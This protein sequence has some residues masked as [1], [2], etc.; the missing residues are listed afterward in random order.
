MRTRTRTGLA[1]VAVI[2]AGIAAP[3]TTGAQEDEPEGAL[4]EDTAASTEAT[5]SV[6]E[7]TEATTTTL[8]TTSTAA[9]PV[10]EDTA[11]AETVP[12][13]EEVF[14]EQVVDDEVVEDTIPVE[15]DVERVTPTTRLDFSQVEE[16]EEGRAPTSSLVTAVEPDEASGTGDSAAVVRLVMAL[17]VVVALLVATLTARYWWYTNPKRGLAPSR[18][19]LPEG[20]EWPG[21]APGEDGEALLDVPYHAEDVLDEGFVVHGELVGAGAPDAGGNGATA[22]AAAVLEQAP[23]TRRGELVDFGAD[24]EAAAEA[25]AVEPGPVVVPNGH[26]EAG[27]W[28]EAPDGGARQVP[29]RSA[30]PNGAAAEGEARGRRPDEA[31]TVQV[32]DV[33]SWVDA[34]GEPERPE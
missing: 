13:E 22:G 24:L 23:A 34:P 31:G 7:T 8:A 9:P 17:L 27:L 2:L 18:A 33:L 6:V 32:A 29:P 20:Y 15:E 5:A 11:P 26:R 25:E 19:V 12:A 4:T 28:R 1:A 14:E 3:A 16:P 21:L 30:G 10:V